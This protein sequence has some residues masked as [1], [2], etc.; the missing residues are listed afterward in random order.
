M[1]STAGFTQSSF[2]STPIQFS[3]SIRDRTEAFRTL[4]P[5]FFRVL[6]L[7]DV[8]H[9]AN[10]SDCVP[11]RIKFKFRPLPNPFQFGPDQNPVFDFV[12]SSPKSGSPRLVDR[13]TVF[14]MNPIQESFVG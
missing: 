11:L 5:F 8:L 6:A 12:S 13:F 4:A 2:P 7:G 10:A 9:G 1:R 3:Q 14:G